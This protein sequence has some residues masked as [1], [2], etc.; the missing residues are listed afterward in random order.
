MK[1]FSSFM[2]T[3][4]LCLNAMA[5]LNDQKDSSTFPDLNEL[6][7]RLL[8]E[9]VIDIEG[10]MLMRHRG[11]NGG[12]SIAAEFTTIAD[13]AA[14]VL[15]DLCLYSNSDLCDYKEDFAQMM[16]KES[17]SFVKVLSAPSVL[18]YD[19]KPR[20][21]VNFVD[22]N[23]QRHIIV[24]ADRWEEINSDFYGKAE[25]K[26][27]LVVHE[28]FSL[29]GLESSDYY[30]RSNELYSLIQMNGYDLSKVSNKKLLPSKC[31]I[32]I[33]NHSSLEEA[34]LR[35]IE[36]FMSEKKY[37]IKDSESQARFV[38]KTTLNCNKGGLFKAD[39]CSVYTEIVDNYKYREVVY[40]KHESHSAWM[41]MNKVQ[42]IAFNKALVDIE[43]C[44]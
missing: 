43:A 9:D 6:D 22:A 36:S 32:K 16:D 1:T 24:G 39:S 27:I 17:D 11:G 40:D 25:R 42:D 23:G 2:L 4:L 12:D 10:M 26:F 33:Q 19:D 7:R 3:M 28:Y 31:A 15:D 8:L 30:P 13:N 38:M 34:H 21:A 44:R 37:E 14:T 18:A 35:D 5:Q 29:L 41:R 20:D